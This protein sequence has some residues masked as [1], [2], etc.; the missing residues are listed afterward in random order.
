LRDVRRDAA[1]T[2]AAADT[3]RLQEYD[4]SLGN[5]GLWKAVTPVQDVTANGRLG[6]VPGCERAELVGPPC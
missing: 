4:P 6:R 3:W 1:S 2:Y 5:T